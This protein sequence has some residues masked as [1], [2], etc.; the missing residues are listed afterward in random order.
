M[1]G[2]TSYGAYV[3]LWRLSREAIM[4]GVRGEKAIR[5]FDEDSTTM[6][7]AAAI[8][9][10]KGQKRE[11]IDAVFFATTTSPYKEKQMSTTIAAACDLRRD[12]TTYDFTNTLRSATSAIKAALDAVKA[13]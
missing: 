2:I 4:K 13:G 12:I 7:V 11:A 8:D 5:N 10:L 3:P 9:C 1:A 6:A